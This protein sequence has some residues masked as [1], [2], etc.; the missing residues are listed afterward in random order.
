M[1]GE[2]LDGQYRM[3][4]WLGSGGF[5]DVYRAE[6]LSTGRAVAIKLLRTDS[7]RDDASRGR[8]IARF[9]REMRA[10]AG[11]HHANIVG[12]VD[13]GTTDDGR[14]YTVFEYVPGITLGDHLRA[15]RG[16]TVASAIDVMLQVLDALAAAHDAGVVHRDLKPDNIMLSTTGAEI[17]AKVLDFGIATFVSGV[18]AEQE[19][20]TLT[21]EAIGTPAYTAPE[22]LRGAPPTTK[23][24]LYAWGL[25]LLECLTGV[26]A[27]SSSSPAETFHIHLSPDPIA[28]PGSLAE[29]RLGTLLAWVMEKDL[30]RRASDAREV[31][32]RLKGLSLE[33]LAN[34]QG[35]LGDTKSWRPSASGQSDSET[36][37]FVVMASQGER[38]QITVAAIEID[39]SSDTA[40]FDVRDELLRDLVVSCRETLQRFGGFV[41][42]E[43]GQHIV[44]YFGFPAASDTD[45]E[46]A[47]RGALDVMVAVSRRANLLLS[48]RGIELAVRVGMH[49]GMI[50]L[51]DEDLDKALLVGGTVGRAMRLASM[52]AGGSIVVSDAVRESQRGR[53]DFERA[54]G[55]LHRLVGQSSDAVGPDTIDGAVGLLGR[56]EELS[57]VAQAWSSRGELRRIVL[58]EGQ[59]GIGKSRLVRALRSRL[60]EDGKGW[61]S[62]R[63]LPESTNDPLAP[64]FDL[65]RKELELQGLDAAAATAALGEG[66]TA[67]GM[68]PARGVPL[69]GPWLGIG[70]GTY[71]PLMASP[72]KQRDLLL[73]E[74]ASVIGAAARERDAAVI[75]EDLHWADPT[76]RELLGRIAA[77]GPGPDFLLVTQRTSAVAGP[78]D[79]AALR[80]TLG[81]L[82]EVAAAE[83][84]RRVAGDAELDE[85]TVKTIVSRADGIPLF[86]GE[87]T[88]S[89]L[90]G[91]AGPSGLTDTGSTT[92]DTVEIPASLRDLLA[93]RLDSQGMA[94]E[95]AQVGAALGRDFD[96]DVLAEVSLRDEGSLL[97]D[98]DQLVYAGVLQPL[99]RVGTPGYRFAHDL[100]REAAHDSLVR[101]EREELHHRIA[102][103]YEAR[104]EVVKGRP[105]LLAR[106]WA[107]SDG[108]A[109]AVPYAHQ[110]A[111]GALMKSSF[112]EAIG[113]ARIGL[114]V[115][116]TIEE[117]VER[118][119]REL[120]LRSPL[121]LSMMASR[122]W[123]DQ[124]INEVVRR[125]MELVAEHT[126]YPASFITRF[127][128]TIFLNS[129]GT[130][131]G[132]VL[133]NCVDLLAEARANPDPAASI[134]Q[135][136]SA[137]VGVASC[138]FVDGRP[139]D[140]VSSLDWVLEHYDPGEHSMLAWMTGMDPGVSAHAVW[141]PIGWL[142]GDPGKARGHADQAVALAQAIHH[143]ESEVLALLYGAMLRHF[144]AD[145]EGTRVWADRLLACAEKHSMAGLS[146]Y[147]DLFRAWADDDADTAAR[148]LGFLQYSGQALGMSYYPLLVAEAALRSGNLDVAEQQIDAALSHASAAPE[149]YCLPMARTLQAQLALARGQVDEAVR[150]WNK[151]IGDAESV[152]SPMLRLHVAVAMAE[153]AADSE[154]R[155]KGIAVIRSALDDITPADDASL[156]ERAR[157]LV[158]Q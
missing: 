108:P 41:A 44:T 139:G 58:L 119:H 124:E 143:A 29:H 26:T 126:D 49:T 75:I 65:I 72:S 136:L 88:R 46:R 24:D 87:L 98:L 109:R 86:L 81:G 83:L 77:G 148:S 146:L 152:G 113:L 134:T 79:D 84:I 36:M 99:R 94:K 40:S 28:L 21:R 68:D 142:L 149:P 96:Y 69:L 50:T 115:V 15:K 116:D 151:G 100:Q 20:I 145:R 82:D 120:D 32:R 89:I 22:Q 55:D 157:Q 8:R 107:M 56:E 61:L 1:I 92:L 156:I 63:C 103:V 48:Q 138:A 80:I 12:V 17:H 132:E 25:V 45:V 64:I 13:S 118:A 53:F 137:H 111:M 90:G 3:D 35:Y 102:D 74:L 5:G 60:R 104:P 131:R 93:S 10:C 140:A 34:E 11:L 85:A 158:A 101:E 112:H 7:A 14:L 54:D 43:V 37:D 144:E 6:Q 128:C 70:L 38:R 51:R 135:Q 110:A 117:P 73:T 123:G 16:M 150:Y 105:G 153:N 78:L 67:L 91:R 155:S 154:P 47:C 97:A 2:T 95:T 121:M 71:Q 57:Q 125:N 52:A 30:P 141:A 133:Q 106:H 76:T 130:F 18:T 42:V 9:K 129:R 62:T 147:A 114:E 31:Y 27:V 122:G 33:G 66:L 23:S 59:A 19:R 4:A 39:V 127:I